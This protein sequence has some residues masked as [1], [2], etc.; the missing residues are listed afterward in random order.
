MTGVVFP[1]NPAC[2]RAMRDAGIDAMAALDHAVAAAIEG[3]APE[4]AREIK[5]AFGRTMSAV[6]D[7]M[8]NPAV[9]AFPELRPDES[10]WISVAKSRAAERSG[11]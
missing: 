8:I 2:A 11:R 5:L 10:T 7:M 6:M 4:Q 9:K 3:L 1:P